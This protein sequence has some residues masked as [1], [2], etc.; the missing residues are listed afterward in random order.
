MML[1]MRFTGIHQK[2]PDERPPGGAFTAIDVLLSS[3]QS[4]APEKEK[5][6]HLLL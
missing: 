2:G 1:K 5:Q 3:S 6:L 4:S